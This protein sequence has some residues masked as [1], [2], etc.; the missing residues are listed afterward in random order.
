MIG[1][2]PHAGRIAPPEMPPGAPVIVNLNAPSEKFWGILGEIGVAG[3]VLRGI[4][5]ES[6]D[7][8][9]AQAARG[10][11]RTIDLVTMFIPLF[12][13]ERVFLD[14]TVGEVESYAERFRRRVGRGVEEF[15]GA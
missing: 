13:L 8:W 15:V 11:E 2:G 7:D 6:F 12:R 3:V 4:S 1:T 9:M 14:E 10:E 5:I